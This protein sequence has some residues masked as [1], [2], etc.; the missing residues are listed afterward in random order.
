MTYLDVYI[1]NLDDPSFDWGNGNWQ[2]NVPRRKSP[3]FPPPAPF[4]LIIQNVERGLL[5]GR[6][7]DWGG[8][9]ARVTGKYLKDFVHTYYSGERGRYDKCIVHLAQQLA[10]LR[11][12]SD[13]L[14]DDKLY[15]LVATEL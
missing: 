6:Q 7:T 3:F 5:D 14:L 15:A 9:T 10:E 4:Q 11:A 1:G 13:T 12:F 2:G 8:W